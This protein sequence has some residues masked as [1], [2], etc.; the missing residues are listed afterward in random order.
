MS[1]VAPLKPSCRSAEEKMELM[2]NH[3]REVEELVT[4][5]FQL[6]GYPVIS[7][8]RCGLSPYIGLVYGRYLHFRILKFPLRRCWKIQKLIQSPKNNVWQVENF[9]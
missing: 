4:A 3:R 9:H 6:R 2:E 8:N 1:F 7:R 5:G